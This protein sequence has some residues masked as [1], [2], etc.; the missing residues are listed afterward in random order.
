MTPVRDTLF[1]YGRLSFLLAL[2]TFKKANIVAQPS[3][4]FSAAGSELFL[5]KRLKGYLVTSAV[6]VTVFFHVSL[7]VIQ[8]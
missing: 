6:Y 1:V 2:S 4:K 8:T 5:A 7:N 3:S